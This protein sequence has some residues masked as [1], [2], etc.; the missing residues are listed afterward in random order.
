MV[1]PCR[2][3]LLH[4]CETSINV[5]GYSLEHVPHSIRDNLQCS[6]A[7]DYGYKRWSTNREAPHAYTQPEGIGYLVGTV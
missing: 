7:S 6:L 1:V 4:I 2:N 3:H 5:T